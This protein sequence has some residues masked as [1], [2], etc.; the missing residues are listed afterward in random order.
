MHGFND[1]SPVSHNN[2]SAYEVATVENEGCEGTNNESECITPH[3]VDLQRQSKISTP[4]IKVTSSI[5]VVPSPD[6]KPK[7]WLFPKNAAQKKRQNIKVKKIP[8]KNSQMLTSQDSR[9]GHLII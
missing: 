6:M 8:N 2:I 5:E 7:V 4:K 3:P 9:K 1:E